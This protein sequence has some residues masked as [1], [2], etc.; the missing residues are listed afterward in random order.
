[1]MRQIMACILVC[2][3]F[4][5]LLSAT[6]GQINLPNPAGTVV[7]S[8]TP[9]APAPAPTSSG[10]G[11]GGGGGGSGG[12]ESSGGG[13][14]SSC[15]PSWTCD[16]W[17]ACQ[18]DYTQTRSC[19]DS[20]SCG[21]TA[22]KPVE[23]QVCTYTKPT[24]P[25][26]PPAPVTPPAQP[27]APASAPQPASPQVFNPALPAPSNNLASMISNNGLAAMVASSLTTLGAFL[28]MAA[29]VLVVVLVV[30]MVGAGA[31]FL[32]KP[33]GLK[34]RDRKKM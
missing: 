9:P 25:P 10:G 21:V 19:T 14:A 30:V 27:A 22:G 4:G 15:T 11:G 13:Y 33:K 34:P 31:F 29:V 8:P 23:L 2:L 7:L 5:G 1:M 20:N 3:F 6:E 28:P 18:R 17:A 24:Q 32:L 12:G 26:T 16:A